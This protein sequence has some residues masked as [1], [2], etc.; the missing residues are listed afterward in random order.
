MKRVVIPPN[1]MSPEA[2]AGALMRGA[3]SSAI[4]GD[5]S[6]T[7]L[8]QYF[9]HPGCAAE[10]Y[11]GFRTLRLTG[12]HDT[13]IEPS[14]GDGAFLNLFPKGRRIGVDLEPRHPEVVRFDYLAWK[15]ITPP[16]STVVIGNPPFGTR[17]KLALEFLCKSCL[18]AHSVGFIL[19]LC[20]RKYALQ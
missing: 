2:I 15:P 17:G 12:K 8:D 1:D 10:C 4:V 14:A 9:T 7:S 3:S 19:P 20:F 11:Q 16:E 5:A 13:F 6:T 18:I